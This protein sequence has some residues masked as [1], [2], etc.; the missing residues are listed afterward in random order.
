MDLRVWVVEEQTHAHVLVG[1]PF[2]P[3][4]KPMSTEIDPNTY[5]NR[6]KIHQ[7]SSSRYPLPSP[8]STPDALNVAFLHRSLSH[9]LFRSRAALSE[10]GI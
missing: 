7:I 8:I 3:I 2:E 4:N 1:F 9:R 6:A 5:P 10:H